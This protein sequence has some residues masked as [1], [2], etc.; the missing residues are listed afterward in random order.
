MAS[1]ML[2]MIVRWV[3]MAEDG[4]RLDQ[5]DAIGFMQQLSPSVERAEKRA[6]RLVLDGCGW[7]TSE[8]SARGC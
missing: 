5:V 1:R 7:V 4:N 8:A 3:D 6:Y 2:E